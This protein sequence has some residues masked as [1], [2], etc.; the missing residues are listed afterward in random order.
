MKH[1]FYTSCN[2]VDCNG[3]CPLCTLAVCKVCNLAEGSLTTDCPEEPSYKKSEDVYNGKID[4]VDG[5]WIRRK[6]YYKGQRGS[7][8][9]KEFPVRFLE[10]N[11][12]WVVYNFNTGE[13]YADELKSWEA[14]G[15]C[16]NWNDK[17]EHPCIPDISSI[18]STP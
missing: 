15:E 4:F 6:E 5:K 14:P 2:D 1:D 12:G 16:M 9:G 3:T 7:S 13:V 11:D 17:L 18:D 8:Y 10:E